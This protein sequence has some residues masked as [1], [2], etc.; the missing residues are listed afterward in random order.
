[1]ST[2]L[3]VPAITNQTKPL[4]PGAQLLGLLLKSTRMPL[5]LDKVDTN[6]GCARLFK[7]NIS[8]SSVLFF[9]KLVVFST[10]NTVFIES[11]DVKDEK[12]NFRFTDYVVTVLIFFLPLMTA[13]N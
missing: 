8:V 10:F 13:V 12:N 5:L 6:Q 7:I 9:K 1:M 11:R 3:L 4:Q 2:L